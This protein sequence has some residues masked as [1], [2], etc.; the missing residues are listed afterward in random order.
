MSRV[1]PYGLRKKRRNPAAL[2]GFLV[3]LLTAVLC[4]FVVQMHE[5]NRSGCLVT[6]KDRTS[7]SQGQGSMRV[8]TKNCGVFEVSDAVFKGRFDSADRYSTIEPGKMYDFTTVG[9]RADVFSWFPNIIRIRE[10][11]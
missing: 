1:G 7:G 11:R 5:T 6:G 4:V 3:V 2:A 10:V 9:F 8:Y